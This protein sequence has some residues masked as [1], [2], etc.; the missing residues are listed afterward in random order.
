MPHNARKSAA[1]NNSAA[2]TP[3]ER[4]GSHLSHPCVA[5]AAMAADLPPFTSAAPRSTE[6]PPYTAARGTVGG[7]FLSADYSE[8]TTR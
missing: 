8:D 6:L 2:P 5:A 1:L 4:K 3:P 7:R